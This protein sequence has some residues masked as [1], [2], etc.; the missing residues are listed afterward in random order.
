[1]ELIPSGTYEPMYKTNK[2]V[3][4][5]VKKFWLDKY[6]TT[7]AEYSNFVASVPKWEKTAVKPI[8]ADGN[9]LQQWQHKKFSLKNQAHKDS[10]V[11]YVSWFAARSYCQWKNKRL[12]DINEWEYAASF[13]MKGK[14]TSDLN[15]RIL[16]WYGKPTPEILPAVHST[17]ENTLGIWDLHGL[18]WE[19]VEDFNTV[20]ITGE[21]R[22]DSEADRNL[23]CG[24]G[25]KGASDFLNYG[26]FMRY[27]FRSS[28]E[29]NY[30]VANL[31]FRCAKDFK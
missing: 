17:W 26:A 31:G 24:A 5:S 19:W 30:T 27:A 14:K 3:R 22:G 8:F 13:S 29:A 11:T 4:V 1:M 15:D 20:F 12:P 7:N 9:Y 28:L 2:N 10:P 23:Y 6:A 18:I 16:L 21:S 25:L